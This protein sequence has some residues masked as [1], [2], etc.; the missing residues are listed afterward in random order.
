[1]LF[2]P[3]QTLMVGL[4][5][6]SP[7][8]TVLGREGILFRLQGGRGGAMPRTPLWP[9]AHPPGA[10]GWWQERAWRQRAPCWHYFSHSPPCADAL[11]WSWMKATTIPNFQVSKLRSPT[12]WGRVKAAP[13]SPQLWGRAEEGWF[14]GKAAR[15]TADQW[16]AGL[17]PLRQHKPSEDEARTGTC[18]RLITDLYPKFTK[19]FQNSTIRK[20]STF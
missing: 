14:K 20:Q 15:P 5:T 13:G 2:L 1:M 8:L 17:E 16:G 7:R 12:R 19:N 18:K 10:G 11:G 9:S 6:E 3:P 4:Q